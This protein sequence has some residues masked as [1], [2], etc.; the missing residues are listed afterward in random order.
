[1]VA[2]GKLAYDLTRATIVNNLY[3]VLN[4]IKYLFPAP[5]EKVIRKRDDVTDKLPF[6]IPLHFIQSIKDD[7]AVITGAGSGIGRL[8]AYRLARLGATVVSIDINTAGNEETA[9]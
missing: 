7:I 6:L 4:V 8:V 3:I 9:K 1:M 2:W 5:F